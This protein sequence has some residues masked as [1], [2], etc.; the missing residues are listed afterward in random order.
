MVSSC[1]EM[2]QNTDTFECCLSEK[3][4]SDN[5]GKIC[6][7]FFWSWKTNK[8]RSCRL[9]L[10]KGNGMEWEWEWEWET[11]CVFGALRDEGRGC[12]GKEGKDQPRCVEGDLHLLLWSEQL[13]YEEGDEGEGEERGRRGRRGW[14]TEGGVK[15]KGGGKRGKKRGWMDNVSGSELCKKR[16]SMKEVESFSELLNTK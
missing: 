9:R 6:S 16:R 12:G 14:K 13:K 11:K 8:G 15:K 2:N 7:F 1:D 4:K 3:E 10:K 5:T